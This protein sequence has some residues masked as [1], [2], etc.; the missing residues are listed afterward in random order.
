MAQAVE[1]NEHHVSEE[2][3]VETLDVTSGVIWKQ[4]LQL[5]IPIFLSAF[6]QQL[7]TLMNTWIVGQFAGKAAVGGI[8]VTQ[9]L[10]DLAV[11]FAVGVGA[12][13]AV[14]VGQYFGAHD[15]TRLSASVHTAIG[16][17]VVGGVLFSVVGVLCVGPVLHI[18]DT[19]EHLMPDALLY[20]H[21][22]FGALVFSLIYNMGSGLMRAIGDSRTPSIILGIA[23][24]CNLILDLIF[25]A[26]LNLATLGAG[27]A[28]A[29]AYIVA[30]SLVL[31]KLSHAHG[32]WQVNLKRIRIDRKIARIMLVTGLPLGVQSAAYSISNI[33]AQTAVNSFGADAVTGWGLSARVDGIIWQS[34]DSLGVAVTTFAAQN[35][36]ARKYDRMHSSLKVSIAMSLALVGALSALLFVFVEPISMFFLP[37]ATVAE[38][39]ALMVRYIAPFYVVY[40]ISSNISGIIRGAGESVRPMLITLF[41]TCILRIAWLLMVVPVFHSME[42]ILMSYPLTWILTTGIYIVYYRSGRWLT[43]ARKKEEARTSIA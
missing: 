25:V 26:G 39:S 16:I 19:P 30:A 2:A 38:W 31:Y 24:A 40:T 18:M 5:Y 29:L 33:I 6:M 36:G 27:I 20:G 34:G 23:L 42:T 28:T 8:Q 22:Y 41:G 4:L 10:T 37:D 11:G 17:S 3:Q 15:D 21:W 43:V 32:P 7:Y 35:F 12:G 1:N 14:I 9:A 13:C